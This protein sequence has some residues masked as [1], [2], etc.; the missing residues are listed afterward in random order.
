MNPAEAASSVRFSRATGR[1]DEVLGFYR[2]AVGL[3]IID[4]FEDHN[5]YSGAMFGLPGAT[6]HLEITSRAGDPV[7]V[8]RCATGESQLVL[9]LPDP[10]NCAAARDRMIAAGHTPVAPANPYW[11]AN[12]ATTFED[13]DGWRVVL[14]PEAFG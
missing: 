1:L 2:D 9:Y 10:T 12:G 11:E 5:S 8:G 6:V 7:D 14:F 3:E 13:P 4:S